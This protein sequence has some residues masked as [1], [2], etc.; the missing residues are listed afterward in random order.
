MTAV[1]YGQ[2]AYKFTVPAHSL[3][4]NALRSP[5]MFGPFGDNKDTLPLLR[6]LRRI[7]ID[8]L[9]G[10]TLWDVKRLRSRLECFVDILKEH[11]D[12]EGEKSLLEELKVNFILPEG[13]VGA[14]IS[15]FA[16][17]SFASLHG[18]KTVEF[19]GLPSW[20]TECMQLTIQGKGGNIEKAD[21]PQLK[22]K[23]LPNIRSYRTKV[24]WVS[25]R[26][27]YQPTLDW[28][29]FAQRNDILLPDDIDKFGPR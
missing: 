9:T 22:V 3:W 19:T 23:R 27:W 2:N 4:P 25:S 1:L 15:M 6:N 7:H 11:A 26:K 14:E 24:Y 10:D 18:I 16:L 21:W 17:E 5:L 12:D 8:V 28:R 29:E 13:S 20:Y